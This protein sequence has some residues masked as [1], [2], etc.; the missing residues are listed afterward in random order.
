M[1]GLLFFIPG[2]L[3]LYSLWFI[4]GTLS[5]WFVKIYNITFVL[6]SMLEAG[7]YPLDAYPARFQVFFT[8][9]IPVAFLTTIPARA[10]VG[11]VFSPELFGAAVA[12]GL[13]LLAVSRAF[14]RFA[15]RFYTSAS[16]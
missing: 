8:F 1:H 12:L 5:I 9:V 7:K 3:V 13:A 15:L 16:S 2:L 10:V 14:W 11:A 4:L 6:R